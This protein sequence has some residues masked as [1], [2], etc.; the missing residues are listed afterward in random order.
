MSVCVG[1]EREGNGAK[2]EM[3]KTGP[4]PAEGVFNYLVSWV[5][6]AKIMEE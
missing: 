2:G 5:S 4:L 6:Y 1:R 3:G